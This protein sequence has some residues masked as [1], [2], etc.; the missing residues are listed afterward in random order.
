[1]QENTHLQSD[2]T[3]ERLRSRA[4]VLRYQAYFGLAFIAGIAVTLIIFLASRTYPQSQVADEVSKL[5]R[6]PFSVKLLED[7]HIALAEKI[8]QLIEATEHGFDIDEA[9]KNQAN[10]LATVRLQSTVNDLRDVRKDISTRISKDRENMQLE[11]NQLRD[12]R[13]S[14]LR[15]KAENGLLWKI[16]GESAFRVAAI[17][18]SIYFISILANISKYLLRVADHLNAVADSI[19]ACILAGISIEKPI[20]ALTPHPIDF[21][22][23]NTFSLRSLRDIGFSISE[24]SSKES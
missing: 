18:M 2:A 13:D 11:I 12:E 9:N 4:I 3:L 8:D 6:P 20:G 21:Q 24:K 15:S 17:L 7:R 10:Q 14:A 22:V 19:E 5:A 16:L 1:M 23:D